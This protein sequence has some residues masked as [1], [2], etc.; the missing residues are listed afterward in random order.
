MNENLLKSILA[1]HIPGTVSFFPNPEIRIHSEVA[2]CTVSEINNSE[3]NILVGERNVKVL[4][5]AA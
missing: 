5:K 2:F 3:Q 4:S 1:H